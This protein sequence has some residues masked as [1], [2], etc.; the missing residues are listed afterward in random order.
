MIAK[1]TKDPTAD[2]LQA[3]I[4]KLDGKIEASREQVK[5][6]EAEKSTLLAAAYSDGDEQARTRLDEIN[7]EIYKA[8]RAQEDMAAAQEPIRDQERAARERE[9]QAELQKWEDTLEELEPQLT[10]KANAVVE[11]A[12]G[13]LRAKV[14]ELRKLLD[15]C[16]AI[17]RKINEL[18]GE[19]VTLMYVAPISLEI[20]AMNAVEAAGLP[21]VISMQDHAHE[22]Q[23]AGWRAHGAL[24]DYERPVA[25]EIRR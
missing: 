4:T 15:R 11:A 23:V 18:N 13:E 25:P 1:K 5:E 16:A 10:A 8:Q 17:S 3:K 7:V 19:N 21:G 20:V 2:E 24:G 12:G 14:G 22:L 6:L 9:R